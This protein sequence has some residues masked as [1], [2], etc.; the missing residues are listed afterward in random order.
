MTPSGNQRPLADRDSS[1][2]ID[3][4]D[5]STR[6]SSLYV[7]VCRIGC[8]SQPGEVPRGQAPRLLRL[9]AAPL[10]QANLIPPDLLR[11]ESAGIHT[12][13]RQ[14]VRGSRSLHHDPTTPVSR[15]MDGFERSRISKLPNDQQRTRGLLVHTLSGLFLVVIS[16]LSLELLKFVAYRDGIHPRGRAPRHSACYLC[17]QSDYFVRLAS[18]HKQTTLKL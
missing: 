16:V 18:S 4:G 13:T 6:M 14:C 1:V 3:H 12:R 17:R 10:P 9:G 8:R 5:V 2:V 15:P 7:R 11:E